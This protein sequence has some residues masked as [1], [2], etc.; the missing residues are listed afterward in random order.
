MILLSENLF[1]IVLGFVWIIG[2]VLQDLRR[3]EVD[4][5]WNF[6]LIGFIVV[7]LIVLGVIVGYV[8]YVR[9]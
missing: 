5:L 9:R 3:K 7:G 6:S 1:L 2:A 4:N 8:V